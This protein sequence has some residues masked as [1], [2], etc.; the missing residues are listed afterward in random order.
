MAMKL[1]SVFL[2]TIMLSTTLAAGL[3]H[4]ACSDRPGTPDSVKAA[5]LST[6]DIQVSWRNRATERV[7]WD[8]EMTDE[9]GT[10]LPLSAGIG[11]GEKSFNSTISNVFSAPQ[12]TDGTT[13]CFRV[14]ARTGPRT[15][16]CV[17]A[18]WSARVCAATTP[19]GIIDRPRRIPI[20]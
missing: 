19:S 18:R 17:S 12:S 9:N 15:E 1:V 8:V 14:R 16:G 10:V 5:P 2:G 6:T 3:A 7:W 20:R 11:R 4:A 13:R